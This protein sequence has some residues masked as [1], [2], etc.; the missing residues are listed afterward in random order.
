MDLDD[1]PTRSGRAMAGMLAEKRHTMPQRRYSFC[2][3]VSTKFGY[4]GASRLSFAYAKVVM[5]VLW[6]VIQERNRL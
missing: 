5:T 3:G 1:R 6:I 2:A 4:H